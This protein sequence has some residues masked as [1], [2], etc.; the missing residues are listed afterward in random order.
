MSAWFLVIWWSVIPYPYPTEKDCM[1]TMKR[2][3]VSENSLDRGL[4]SFPRSWCLPA[5]LPDISAVTLTPVITPNT[6]TPR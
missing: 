4:G 5:P 1:D 6:S 2:M 3:S